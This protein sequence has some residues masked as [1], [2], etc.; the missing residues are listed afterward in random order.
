MEETYHIKNFGLVFVSN[1]VILDRH[2]VTEM[3]R[4]EPNPDIPF[5][6]WCFLSG[7]EEK[8]VELYSVETLLAADSSVEPFLFEPVGTR[9]RRT[10]EGTFERVPFEIHDDDDSSA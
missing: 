5:S 10:D 1:F 4:K 9:F 8:D 7:E 2:P 3:F 6:G